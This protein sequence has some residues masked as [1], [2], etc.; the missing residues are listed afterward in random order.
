[1]PQ[2]L[3]EQTKAEQILEWAKLNED[4]NRGAMHIVRTLSLSGIDKCFTSVVD[5]KRWAARADKSY[6][7]EQA[8]K[9]NRFGV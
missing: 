9:G 8:L 1:M 5:A 2:P 6:R 7:D 4:T 3:K